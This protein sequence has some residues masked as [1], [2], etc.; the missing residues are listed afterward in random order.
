MYNVH[1]IVII[2]IV[3]E[4]RF[5]IYGSVLSKIMIA[6]VLLIKKQ[7]LKVCMPPRS[8]KISTCSNMIK[9]PENKL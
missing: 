8:V 2:F 6:K 9:T 3:L 4:K 1:Y 5:F 7:T